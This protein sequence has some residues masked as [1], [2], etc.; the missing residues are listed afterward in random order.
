MSLALEARPQ[1]LDV[2]RSSS[3]PARRAIFRWSW[4]L[5][6]REWRQQILV[7]AL[8]VFA[9]AATTVG[10]ALVYN[11][12][13]PLDS[14]M[15]NATA[16]MTFV[17]PDPGACS[18][19]TVSLGNRTVAEA[20]IWSGRPVSNSRFPV[21]VWHARHTRTIVRPTIGACPAATLFWCSWENESALIDGR[22]VGLKPIW[23]ST[24]T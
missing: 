21:N 24:W 18:A 20:F 5:F 17:G 6:R 8:M 13:L 14:A 4:R 3:G 16:S 10:V 1:E 23:P 22:R 2:G 11:A 9:V 19:G 15:G 12:G 7:V